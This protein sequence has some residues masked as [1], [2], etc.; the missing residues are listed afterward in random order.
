MNIVTSLL[1][2]ET[3]TNDFIKHLL[4]TVIIAEV[5]NMIYYIHYKYPIRFSRKDAN[6]CVKNE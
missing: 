3:S 1:N 5:R 6:I 4:T 2:N